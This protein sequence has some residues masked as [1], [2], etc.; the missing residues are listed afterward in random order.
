MLNAVKLQPSNASTLA[1]TPAVAPARQADPEPSA[2][3]VTVS[4][5][6]RRAADGMDRAKLITGVVHGSAD[7][8]QDGRVSDQE[9]QTETAQL[10]LRKALLAGGPE[11]EAARQAY[12]A[13]ASLSDVQR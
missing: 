7:T 12:Q 9:Q 5:A 2:A 3:V 1:P 4:A 6:G 13:I 8:N 10:A 11:L